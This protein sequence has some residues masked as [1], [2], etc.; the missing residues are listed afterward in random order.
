MMLLL[1]CAWIS[2]IEGRLDYDGDGFVAA[3]FGGG[4]CDDADPLVN[5]D[6]DEVCGNALDEDCDGQARQEQAWYRDA[7]GDGWG[8]LEVPL[9]PEP[10]ERCANAGFRPRLPEQG[11]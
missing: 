1:G 8:G 6:A 7:D 11:S 3:S 9:D 4:D 5:P 2:D 10:S